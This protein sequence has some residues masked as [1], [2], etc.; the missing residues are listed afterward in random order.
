MARK[1]QYYK[2]I[3]FVRYDNQKYYVAS[4]GG[5]N[6]LLHRFIWLCE[7]GAIPDGYDVHH[8]DHDFDHNEISNFELLTRSEHIKKHFEESS[9]EFKKQTRDNMRKARS[10]Q[11]CIDSYKTPEFR[12]KMSEQAKRLWKEGKMTKP[13]TYICEVCGK[14]YT[15]RSK[16]AAHRFCSY[17]CQR[18]YEKTPIKKICCI[19]GK[20][21]TSFIGSVGNTCSRSCACKLNH[22]HRKNT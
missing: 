19:C 7:R 3:K 21:Y 22:K 9:E 15:R 11:K 14:E 16:P 18:V 13:N 5:G 4:I 20:E 1:I 10:S 8:I 12:K 6:V 2:G 17:E